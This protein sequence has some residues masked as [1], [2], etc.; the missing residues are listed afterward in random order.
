MTSTAPQFFLDANVPPVLGRQLSG[1]GFAVH[2]P[3]ALGTSLS[4]QGLIRECAPR[5]WVLLTLN[6]KDFWRLHWLWMSLREWRH[7]PQA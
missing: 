6:R 3:E 5:G 2:Y 4:D 7:I 1:I